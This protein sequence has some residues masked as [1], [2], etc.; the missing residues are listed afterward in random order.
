GTYGGGIHRWVRNSM[1]HYSK[2]S[3]IHDENNENSISNNIIRSIL[4][5]S[6]GNIWLGTGDGLSKLRAEE[7]YKDS[8][9]FQTFKNIPG[10]K[11]SLSHNYILAMYESNIGEIWI[12]TFGGG[13]NRLIYNEQ[14]DDFAFESY[15]DIDGLPNNV[16]KGILEDDRNNLWISTN[17]GL[18]KFN[19]ENKTFKNYDVNDGLQSNEFQELA[20]LKRENGEM[21]FGGINGFNVF[22]PNDIKDNNLPPESV[23]TKLSIFNKAIGVGEEMNG[24]IVLDKP[25]DQLEE[26]S[27]KYKENSFSIDFT[28]LHYAAPKKN[29]FAYMLEGF[30]EDWIHTSSGK[31]TASYTHLEPGTYE[32]FVKTSNNDGVWDA[33]PLVLRIKVIPPFWRTPIAFL[34]YC[35]LGIGFVWIFISYT[36]IGTREKHQLELEHLEKGKN[37]EIQQMKLEFFTNISHE[38]RTPLTLIKGP[39]DYLLKDGDKLD[40]DSLRF[41]YRIIQKNTD[42]LMKLVNQI[43]DFRKLN[44]GKMKLVVRKGII[45][46]FVQEIGETF[47][48]LAHKKE[49]KFEI[50]K[51]DEI[52]ESWYDHDAVEKI[53]SNL[54]S[55]AFKFT[56]D[57]GSIDV[58]VKYETKTLDISDELRSNEQ[59][60]NFVRIEVKDSGQG[61]DVENQKQIFDRFYVDKGPKGQNS[62]GVGVG[63]SFVKSLVELHQGTIDVKSDS[64][65]GTTFIVRLPANIEAYKNVEGITCKEDDDPDF[66]ARTS[67]MDSFA[68]ETN[69]EIEDKNMIKAKSKKPILLIVDDNEEIR[70]FISQVFQEYY[71]IYE[72]ENGKLAFEMAMRIMPNLIIT[73]VLMPIMDGYELCEKLKSTNTTSHIPVIMLT[74]KISDENELLGRKIGADGYVRKPFDIE[75]LRIQIEN[76]LKNRDQL[77]K[78]FN[79]EVNMLP[80]EVTVNSVDESFLQ[81]A[82]D[83]VERN[84]MNTEFNVEMLVKEM[85]Y[86]RSNLYLKFKEIT[87]LSSS[88]FI[89]NIRLKRAIQLFESSNLSVKEIMYMTGFNTASY[90][91]KCF[92]KQFGV[93]PSEYVKNLDEENVS[94]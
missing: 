51:P 11:T 92:K 36:L 17:K 12:G 70:Q 14:N 7:K 10:D 71:V 35:L 89:R 84:M 62:E 43:L 8:P 79:V 64:G 6:A 73:D 83:I 13:I 44:Q 88:E 9:E 59:V 52:V 27:L 69:D 19:P 60:V 32:F 1:G 81:Q 47:Q 46:D 80:K 16:I 30:D 77:R 61:I 50:H 5:D 3:F 38:F 45:S 65:K 68:I 34:F 94:Q 24:R 67:E 22:Y 86:S 72:A 85:G 25:I 48:F 33:T 18:S 40:K 91:A 58:V 15:S 66:L 55:N 42:T 31:R 21:I 39:L 75:L 41:Q 82:M 4:E 49:T 23:I 87:G 37:D 28:A 29:K 76:I 56:P 90:F 63:L 2:S 20:C 54:L 26:I 57:G 74:A 53:V 78:R 93:V